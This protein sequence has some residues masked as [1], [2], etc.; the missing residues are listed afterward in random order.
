M[1]TTWLLIGI[2]VGIILFG[3]LLVT[4]LISPLK[5][6]LLFRAVFSNIGE[7]LDLIHSGTTKTIG[8]MKIIKEGIK[9]FR[10]G[11]KR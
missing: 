9:F 4:W 1:E 11:R 7:G 5:K 8:R 10:P 3:V 2:I 6:I